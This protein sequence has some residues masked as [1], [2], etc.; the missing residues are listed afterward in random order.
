MTAKSETPTIEPYRMLFPLAWLGAGFSVGLW[1]AVALSNRLGWGLPPYPASLHAYATFATFIFPSVSGF[2]LTALPRFTGTPLPSVQFVSFVLGLYLVAL[3]GFALGSPG[4]VCLFALGGLVATLAFARKR[5]KESMTELPAYLRAFLPAGLGAAV[6]GWLLILIGL[7]IE[8]YLQKAFPE[9]AA[10]PYTAAGRTLLFYYS[11][12]FI[13]LGAGSRIAVTIQASDHADKNNWR[14]SLEENQSEP[15]MVTALLFAAAMLE[16]AGI[17]MGEDR[18]GTL[19]RTGALLSFSAVFYW[20]L[21]RFRVY[22]NSF[23]RAVSTGLWI[24][25]WMI[26]AGLAARFL[27]GLSSVHWVH[28]FF[29]GGLSLLTFSVMTRVILSHGKWDLNLE[30]RS[31]LLWLPIGLLVLAAATRASAHLLPASYMNHLGYGAFLFVL[32]LLLWLAR[33]MGFLIRHNK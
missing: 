19:V 12:S 22:R 4:L 20:L 16:I 25:L 11:I 14:R 23:R 3:A 1:M 33:F 5:M 32:A 30:N 17:L 26:L 10:A 9:L 15:L 18:A 7:F 13:V 24:S 6:L 21:L 29:V 31:F 2:L 27:T 8:N 28:L